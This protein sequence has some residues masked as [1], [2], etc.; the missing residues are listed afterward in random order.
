MNLTIDVEMPVSIATSS[1]STQKTKQILKQKVQLL[2]KKTN[3]SEAEI[4][5][6]LDIHYQIMVGV[7]NFI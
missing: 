3:F 6:L 4:N 7:K 2:M 1:N 5:R